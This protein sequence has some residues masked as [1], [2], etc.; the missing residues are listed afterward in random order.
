M[1]AELLDRFATIRRFRDYG[2]IG[3]TAHQ[4]GN[5]L[6]DYRMIINYQNPNW[7]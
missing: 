2:H 3:L 7:G 4:Y 1:R 6:A 5:A